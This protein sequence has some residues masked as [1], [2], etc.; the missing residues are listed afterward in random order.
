MKVGDLVKFRGEWH[1]FL[2][3]I[4]EVGVYAGRKD[5]KV[6]WTDGSVETEQSKSMVVVSEGR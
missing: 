6:L 5:I 4:I 2:A 3:V 1:T